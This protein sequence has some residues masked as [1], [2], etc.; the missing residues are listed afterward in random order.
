MDKLLIY[1]L[2]SFASLAKH[3]F[4]SGSQFEVVAYCA[5]RDYVDCESKD[6]IPVVPFDEV[7]VSY[8]PD[9]FAMFVAVGYSNMRAR[10][11]MYTTAA[12]EGYRFANFVHP[13]AFV[14]SSAT[15]GENVLVLPGT[16]IE[17]FAKIGD[18]NVIWSSVVISHNAT[19]Q[20]HC[21]LASKALVG[22]FSEVGENSFVG[23]GATVIQNV[24]LGRE[25]L[26]AAG[27][28][29]TKDTQACSKMVGT[30]AR[31]VATHSDSGIEI[32]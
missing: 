15:L 10:E 2:G 30:P 23:F 20:D 4:A 5:D 7:T 3:Y 1:G 25:T 22:G 26:A 27:S 14:D 11:R 21:F 24:R 6:G 18:N 28:L 32:E 17:P 12:N 29:V 16:I 31:C 8:P 13:T 19:V 9:R